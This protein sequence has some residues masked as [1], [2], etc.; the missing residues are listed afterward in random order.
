MPKSFLKRILPG[1]SP[2]RRPSRALQ[3]SGI[4]Y[5]GGNPSG[6]V[7]EDTDGRAWYIWFDATGSMRVADAATAEAAGFS[8]TT[9]GL[10]LAGKQAEFIYTAN[11]ALTVASGV[12]FLNKAGS[13]AVMTLAAPVA[14]DD[15]GLTMIIMAQTAFAHTVTNTSPGFNNGGAASDVGTYGGAVGDNFVII[16]RNG[17]WHVQSLRN[18]T[19]A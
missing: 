13:A 8:F 11:G 3:T 4:P 16:A 18:V 12:H 10:S 19:L 15:D 5:S 17:I 14:A 7:L 6:F 1:F 9:G 2:F